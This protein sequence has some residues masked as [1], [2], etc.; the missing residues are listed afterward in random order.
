MNINFTATNIPMTDAIKAYA[1]KKAERIKKH[2]HDIMHLDFTFSKTREEFTVSAQF[3]I[4]NGN[5]TYAKETSHDMYKA[6]DLLVDK[7]LHII[8]KEKNR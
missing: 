5:Q 6:I 3:K 4:P 7:V 8:E 1:E 2:S